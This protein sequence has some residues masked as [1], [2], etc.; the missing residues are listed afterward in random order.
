M[1]NNILI[2][3]YINYLYGSDAHIEKEIRGANLPVELDD[4]PNWI[5]ECML[6]P[7]SKQKINCLRKL[8]EMTAMNPFY[9]YRI[10]RFIDAVTQTYEPT[11]KSGMVPEV[12]ENV[13]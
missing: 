12:G 3:S 13:N 11:D 6:L 4:K 8:R 9:K 10:D 1:V 7:E 2:E 5:R